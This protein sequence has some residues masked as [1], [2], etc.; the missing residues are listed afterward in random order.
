MKERTI[1]IEVFHRPPDYDTNLDPV[2]RL[3]AVEVRKRLVQ[4]YQ[5]SAHANELRIELNPGSY[6]P[7]FSEPPSDAH[8][9]QTPLAN[10]PSI[11]TPPS[12]VPS[13]QML[14]AD[15]PSIAEPVSQSKRTEKI[16]WPAGLIVSGLIVVIVALGARYGRQFNKQRSALEEVWSPLL[17]S[18]KPILLCV[19]GTKMAT[20]AGTQLI[21]LQSGADDDAFL[22]PFA[23]R[24]D[25]V[26]FSDVQVLSRFS[27]LAD[28]HGQA[29]RVQNSRTT[30][31]SQLRE[32]PVVLIGALNN[33]WTLNR[34][35]SLRFHFQRPVDSNPV[36][37]I[38]D[39]QHPESHAWQ[40]NAQARASDVLKDYAIAARFTDEGTGQIVL[41][42]AGITGSGTRAAGEF[43]TD[44]AALKQLADSAGADWGKKNFEVVL[45]AQVVNGMQGKPTVEAK[46]FW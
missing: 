8:I 4:Y 11:Q 37:W 13:I 33:D 3:C 2:V 14:P 22:Q 16:Y 18:S 36:Y 46:T 27:S 28:A 32:G 19:G 25:F 5:S 10:V 29:F 38:A 44:E 24:N 30:V 7:V 35:S 31:S 17:T 12:D 21:E 40:V 9:L 43:L 34:T 39:T 20:L 26:P 41:V 23:N 45:S 6:V 42:A 15:V 1:G